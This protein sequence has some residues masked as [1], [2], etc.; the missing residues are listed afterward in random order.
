LIIWEDTKELRIS[1]TQGIFS[2][3]QLALMSNAKLIDSSGTEVLINITEWLE[4]D[5]KG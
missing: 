2:K 3:R 5:E 1:F 4:A